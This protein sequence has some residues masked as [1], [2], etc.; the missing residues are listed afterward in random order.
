[1]EYKFV[2]HYHCDTSQLPEFFVKQLFGNIWAKTLPD[3]LAKTL[4]YL[5]E[6]KLDELPYI[7]E[8]FGSINHD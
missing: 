1:M 6:H 8:I 4:I 2:L 5:K 3:V 7:P